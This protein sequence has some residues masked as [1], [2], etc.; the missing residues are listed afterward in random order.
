MTLGLDV[1]SEK[2]EIYKNY[3]LNRDL[4]PEYYD[5]NSI[6]IV[7]EYSDNLDLEKIIDYN[8]TESTIPLEGP[9]MDSP[10]PMQ[11]HDIRHTGRSPYNTADNPYKEKWWFQSYSYFE[12]SPVIDNNGIIYFGAW[13]RHLYAVYPNGLPKWK[14][15]VHGIIVSSP[16]I[17]DD[18]TIYVGTHWSPGYGTYLWA[19]HPTGQRK[20]QY[21]TGDIYAPPTVGDGIVYSTDGKKS[22][23]ALDSD[24]GHL[25]WKYTTGDSVLSSPAIGRDG[26]IYCGSHDKNIYALYSNG[27]FKWKFKTGGWVHG[28]PTIADDDTIYCGSDDDYLYALYPNGTMKWRYKTGAIWGSPA[29]DKNGI[30]YTGT[31]NKKLHA[32]YPDGT[33]KWTTN[34][35][36][37]IWGMSPI[38]SDE[39]IIYVGT[40]NFAYRKGGP[41]YAINPDGTIRYKSTFKGGMF[42]SS[43]AIGDDGTIYIC[44]R[45]QWERSPGA[46]NDTGYLRA[47]NELDPNAPSAPIIIG[48]KRVIPGIEYKYYFKST[49]PNGEY[50]YYWIDWGDGDYNVEQWIGAYPSGNIVT[51]SHKWSKTG[52]FTIQVK[53]KDTRN[54]WSE[55]SSYKINQ[56]RTKASSYHWFLERFP[57]LERLLGLMI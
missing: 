41:F 6:D 31:W 22:I 38:I 29:L 52:K 37:G 18:G 45:K 23:V 1:K 8:I 46:F 34:V 3:V 24:Y 27:T 36:K 57:M 30:I 49:S 20:W 9:P 40:C 44:T 21:K 56:P 4:Y 33:L 14:F 28:I 26:T 10:W 54:I 7:N 55:W 42:W 15:K 25:I 13:D 35:S 16:A 12:S 43:P 2:D 32:I 48:P 47:F 5:F 19:V 51:R 17:G 50:L 11:G 53:V 39:G